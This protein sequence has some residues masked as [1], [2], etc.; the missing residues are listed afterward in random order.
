MGSRGI[1][2]SSLYFIWNLLFFLIAYIDSPLSNLS[3][4]P[5]STKE[6]CFANCPISA[7]GVRP[8][9]NNYS[10]VLTYSVTLQQKKWFE[11]SDPCRQR[12]WAD[13]KAWMKLRRRRA[14]SS[15][16]VHTSSNQYDCS[17][18]QN[19][20][21]YRIAHTMTTFWWRSISCL[22]LRG[23]VQWLVTILCSPFSH[24]WQS[25]I[26]PF[27]LARFLIPILLRVFV[28]ETSGGA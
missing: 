16:R 15:G 5:Y 20:W 12:T 6:T 7:R 28:D 4:Y 27:R 10:I 26:P 21:M 25:Y 19:T 3:P 11:C 17:L 13:T 24:S 1:L 9:T 23:R 18:K 14:P 22:T 8:S 2:T